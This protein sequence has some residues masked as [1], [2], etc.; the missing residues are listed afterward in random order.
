MGFAKHANE[1]IE[2]G[3]FWEKR[4]ATHRPVENVVDIPTRRLAQT[5]WHAV[6]VCKNDKRGEE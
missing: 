6:R 5:L 3:G 1:G 4:E 2:I